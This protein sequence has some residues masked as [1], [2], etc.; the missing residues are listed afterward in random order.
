MKITDKQIVQGA[1][2]HAKKLNESGGE[3]SKQ[4]IMAFIAG[5][6]FLR[7]KLEEENI[8]EAHDKT[9]KNAI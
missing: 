9:E 3:I 4:E 8:L 1:S 5:A 2:D 6:G 7:E